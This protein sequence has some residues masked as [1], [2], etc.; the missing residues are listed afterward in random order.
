MHEYADIAHYRAALTLSLSRHCLS[1]ED[2]KR[3]PESLQASDEA[4][5]TAGKLDPNVTVWRQLFVTLYEHRGVVHEQAGQLSEAVDAWR[6]MERRQVELINEYR[7][8]AEHFGYR[9]PRCRLWMGD[10]LWRLGRYE[11]AQAEFHKFRDSPENLKLDEPLNIGLRAW[12]FANCADPEFREPFQ[13][14]ELIKSA[15]AKADRPR[16]VL[17][18][19][20]AQYRALN[21]RDAIMTLD[22]AKEMKDS[23]TSALAGLF[24][25]MAH[26]QLAGAATAASQLDLTTEEALH[27]EAAFKSYREAIA[28]EDGAVWSEFVRVRAEAEKVTG[29]A[30]EADGETR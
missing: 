21:Y 18:L 11:E 17:A 9:L 23:Y 6:E 10:V 28:F 13:A 7:A 12:F 29:F 19:G 4:I 15:A 8:S 22:R 2:L 26:W 27:R 1:L 30:A 3:F 5:Q 24:L 20:A 25:A 14:I 16:A